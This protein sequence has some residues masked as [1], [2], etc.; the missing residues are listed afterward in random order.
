MTDQTDHSEER[1]G[2]WEGRTGE[3]LGVL[4]D[5][6]KLRENGAKAQIQGALC[7]GHLLWWGRVLGAITESTAFSV[8]HT[9]HVPRQT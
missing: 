9:P 7:L 2:T 5:S 1:R 8:T 4:V 6:W 3:D